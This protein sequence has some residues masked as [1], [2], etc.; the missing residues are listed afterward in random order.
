MK[1]IADISTQLL[2]DKLSHYC[3]I[4]SFLPCVESAVSNLL[5][6]TLQGKTRASTHEEFTLREKCTNVFVQSTTITWS[7]ARGDH[8]YVL[9]FCWENICISRTTKP[10]KITA[11]QSFYSFT[12]NLPFVV[13]HGEVSIYVLQEAILWFI[14]VNYTY[15]QP[16]TCESE[17]KNHKLVSKFTIATLPLYHYYL[18]VTTCLHLR[19]YIFITTVYTCIHHSICIYLYTVYIL[20]TLQSV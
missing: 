19:L 9:F 5:V 7:Q 1:R 13:K 3:S 18:L 12:D 2:H 6:I 10:F 11:V 8:K 4:C 14:F 16:V 17:N 20:T 15:L